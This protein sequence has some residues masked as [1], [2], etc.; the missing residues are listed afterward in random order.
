M[1]FGP[2]L[3]ALT[4]NKAGALLIAL[5]IAITLAIVTNAVYIIKQ[6]ADL[7][8]RPSGMDETNTFFALTV[9]FAENFDVKQT[10][11]QDLEQIRALDG[12]VAATSIASIP[13]SGAG[14]GED[15][16]LDPKHPSNETVGFGN[17]MTDEHG[18]DALGIQLVAGRNFSAEEITYRGINDT[19]YPPVVLVSQALANSLFPDGDALGQLV[20]DEPNSPH[21]TRIVGIYE[22]MQHAWPTVRSPDP[23]HSAIMPQ[24]SLDKQMNFLVRAEPGMR[25]QVMAEAEVLLAANHNRLVR[26]V[27]SMEEM[28]RR[29]YSRDIAM[30]KLL[31]GVI[32]LL[33]FITALGIVGLAWF[34][35]NQR[36]KQIGTRRALGARKIDILR[37]FMV[38]NWVI[39]TI[40][41]I[42]GVALS[43]VLNYLLDTHFQTGK[44]E[45]YYIPVGMVFLWLLG[46]LAV[47]APA[48]RAAGIPPALAT[49]SV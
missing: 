14:W 30:V 4:R 1:E 15:F 13:L 23:D 16:Y 29:Y 22:K 38:E 37:Y 35:V 2:I 42:L 18:I 31:S 45:W 5:Q 17:F 20:Y 48:R 11:Q 10:W 41:L 7:M 40:G 47:L 6:R 44:I 32:G 24:R 43:L 27:R 25:D 3:S 19:V 36:R 9:A 8:A 49:R 39:T 46:Q 28:K 21:P 34:S 26:I 33:I 12:V